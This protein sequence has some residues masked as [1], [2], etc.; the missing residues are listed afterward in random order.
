MHVRKITLIVLLAACDGESAEQRKVRQTRAGIARAESTAV[1]V[2]ASPATGL[3]SKEQLLERL[4]RAGVSPRELTDAAKGP[5]W[6]GQPAVVIAA[7]GGE[8]HAWIY[9]DSTARRAATDSL[10]EATGAPKGGVPPF[11]GP[12][13][14]VRQ[15]NL[16]AM[17]TGGSETNQERIALAL[18]AGVPAAKP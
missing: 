6:M 4:V 17:I 16:A 15:N 7:G 1:R 5:A 13:L 18:Q 12:M 9:R 8:I 3:W 2:A 14:F 11:A 10:D